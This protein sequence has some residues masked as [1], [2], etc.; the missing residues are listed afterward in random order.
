VPGP[1]GTTAVAKI[2]GLGKLLDPQLKSF[3]VG[4]AYDPQSKAYYFA[5]VRI[6]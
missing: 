5:I 1:D 3:G 4:W 6:D 2:A